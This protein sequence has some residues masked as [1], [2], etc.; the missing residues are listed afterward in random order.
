MVAIPEK[1]V[2]TV[3][4]LNT[5]LTAWYNDQ[6]Q[7][8]ALKTREVL[9]RKTI[10]GIYFPEPI[11]GA[12]RADIGAGYDIKLTQSWTRSVD[13]AAFDALSAKLKKAK[14]DE[15]SV[16]EWKPSLIKAGY[17]ELTPEQRE[18]FD[19]CLTIKP[20]DT[21]K[22]EIVPHAQDNSKYTEPHDGEGVHAAS[23]PHK[24]R[25]RKPKPQ[26]DEGASALPNGLQPTQLMI[27]SGA[28]IESFYENGW[29]DAL[30]VEHGYLVAPVAA[31][32]PKRG[33][34]PK[35][36]EAASNEPTYIC[37]PLMG[38]WTAEDF[39]KQGWTR[40]GLIEAGYLLPQM[41]DGPDADAEANPPAP[42][43]RGRKPKAK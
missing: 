8:A 9:Q 25:G 22:L 31:E 3:E 16:I 35:I 4:Q 20:S 24:R 43:K 23:A 36:E 15:D 34:K 12:Q 2:Y 10:A 32:K 6:Q 41:P 33:R 17:D 39:Y 30:L 14:I 1:P 18:V 29:T 26:P 42:K 19:E 11:E 21:P 27:D 13:I 7:L 28:S 5:M 37:G 40:E 38:E